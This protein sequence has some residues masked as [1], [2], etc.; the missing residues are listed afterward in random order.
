MRQPRST[1]LEGYRHHS[2]PQ[3]YEQRLGGGVFTM[4]KSYAFRCWEQGL[5]AEQGGILCKAKSG[6]GQMAGDYYVNK[7]DA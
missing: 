2:F 1:A 6:Q 7:P 3:P 5:Y 4:Y